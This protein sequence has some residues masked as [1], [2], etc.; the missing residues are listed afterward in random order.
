MHVKQG[1]EESQTSHV[2][3]CL[4]GGDPGPWGSSGHIKSH[5]RGEAPYPSVIGWELPPQGLGCRNSQVL[6]IQEGKG[7]SC[8]RRA[9]KAFQELV[10]A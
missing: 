3:D 5:V 4:T 6:L 8:S 7:G 9:D 2:T 1:R 10:N